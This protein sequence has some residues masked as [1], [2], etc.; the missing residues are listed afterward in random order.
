MH[1]KTT[2][3]AFCI[4]VSH[5]H[6]EC[7][8]EPHHH[9]P[10]TLLIPILK[11]P[12]IISSE[13][14]LLRVSFTTVCIPRFLYS[15]QLEIILLPTMLVPPNY[16]LLSSLQQLNF[17]PA[18]MSYD[19]YMAICKPRTTPLSWTTESALALALCCWLAGSLII[20]PPLGIAQLEFCDS[21]CDW[22]FWLWYISYFTDNLLRHSVNRENCFEFC[23]ADTHFYLTVCGPLLY[24]HHQDH[25]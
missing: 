20:L 6:V 10:Y 13:I 15:W 16:F 17:S 22:S 3:S 7:G 4:F 19:R 9:H 11:R 5:L 14:S 18:A 25:S 24:I 21:E 23:C 8:W 1:S 12:C 2:S